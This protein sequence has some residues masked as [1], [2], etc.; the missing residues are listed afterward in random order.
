MRLVYT[1][2]QE[3][4][5]EILAQI[6]QKSAD[7]GRR[8]FYI[9]PNSLSF[10]KERAVLSHLKGQASFAVTVTRF[11]QMARYFVLDSVQGQ[12]QLDDSGLV[13]VFYRALMQLSDDDLRI[14][15]RLRLEAGFIAQLVS[16]YQELQV[17]QM[18]VADLEGL[19]PPEKQADLE[20]I[21][22]A[23]DDILANYAYQQETQIG[24]L[25]T[26]MRSKTWEQDLSAVTV[27]IDGFTRFSAQEDSL[28]SLMH[29]MGAEI[30]IG[31]YLSQDAMRSSF[32]EGNVYQ[33]S[34]QFIQDLAHRFEVKAEYLTSSLTYPEAFSR[35]SHL[36][37]A[38]H[39]FTQ[40][41][42]KL[43]ES[44]HQALELWTMP[45]LQEEIEGVATAIRDYIYQGY[46][47]KDITV[48]LG[49]VEAYRQSLGQIFDKYEI[50]Y[51]LS[52]AHKMSSHPLV[53]VLDSLSR[54]FRYHLRQDDVRNLIKS[55]LY[56]QISQEDLDIW[57]D[58]VRYAD[59]Q[60]D[61]FFKAFTAGKKENYNLKQL[62]AIREKLMQP[63]A[64]LLHDKESSNGLGHLQRLV[65]FFADSHLEANL[66]QMVASE[67]EEEVL[68]TQEVFKSFSDILAQ[69]QLLFSEESISMTQLLDLLASAMLNST[70]RTIPATVDTVTVQSYDLVEPHANRLVFALG[71]SAQNFPKIAQND[72]LLSDEERQLINESTDSDKRLDLPSQENNQKNLYTALSVFHAATEKLV[73]SQPRFKQEEEQTLSPYVQELLD[74]GLSMQNKSQSLTRLQPSD[75]GNA[76]SLL[77]RVLAHYQLA[78]PNSQEQETFWTVAGR[79]LRRYL[80]KAQLHLPAFDGQL[81]TKP[82]SQEVM[83]LRF[84]ENEPLRLSASALTT[85]YDNQ[86]RYFLQYVLGLEERASIHPDARQHGVYLHRVF[87]RVLQ[88]HSGIPFDQ[89]MEKAISSTNQEVA[90]VDAYQGDWSGQY[91][92]S[93]L[94]TIAR[95]TGSVVAED[96]FVLSQAE[97]KQ[98]VLPLSEHLSVS[99]IIDRIDV[100]KDQER[101]GIV[102]Y[103]SS[104]Q[105]FDIQKFY[106]GLSPQL[107]TYIQALLQEEAR[108]D[109]VFGAMYLQMQEPKVAL[110][111]VS[112]LSD[113][114]S[115][116]QKDMLYQGIFLKEASPYL[117]SGPY[118]ISS[119][120][121]FEEAE[122]ETLLAYNRHLFE[123]AEAT[124]RQGH[125]AINP[126]TEDGKVVAGTQLK[127]ITH[128]EA[129]HHFSQ[130]RRWLTIPRKPKEAFFERIREELGHD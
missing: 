105:A 31:T 98:F 130:A 39:A 118:A 100:L 87:E 9:A 41:D 59:I 26:A 123:R 55:G 81:T 20:K 16:L 108:L 103:K 96:H 107:V 11:S 47:Y 67:D 56:G 127:A 40:T 65:A 52:Y 62:N 129:N 12:K 50:P 101:S 120:S 80:E 117:T 102:D 73:L 5:T 28:V 21:F 71:M 8:V 91:S 125:F 29:D 82:V 79:Y 1:D 22:A 84:P 85:F 88:D 97:E 4:L 104:K 60:G 37:E 110:Q 25:L 49:D 92:L 30:V 35:L 7:H 111:D 18:T 86:Y 109:K 61:A 27:I 83:R 113:A 74:F 36:F 128:F 17:A 54:I 69:A 3:D 13:M 112:Q 53:H 121:T 119:K 94:E 58:Y 76:K 116:L 24:Q 68:K 124:I 51:H 15:G 122:I 78:V 114:V 23:V 99:G 126:Y 34:F 95:A 42:L 45:S 10:D 43:T 63:L 44:E 93:R 6:A 2:L 14:F 75:I 64:K 77:S 89:K 19:N 48:L 106:N 32:I 38:K 115:E 57:D 66:N 46:R 72:S 70:Y 90:F 33:A